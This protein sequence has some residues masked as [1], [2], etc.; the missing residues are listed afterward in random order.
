MKKAVQTVI[1]KAW[2]DEQFRS[3]FIA[4][5]KASIKK[6]T[7]L[8]IPASVKL[9]IND[10]T[11]PNKM[12][13]NIPPKP[14]IDDM[15]LSDEQLEQVAGGEVL[16][17]ALITAGIAMGITAGAA[18]LGGAAAGAAAGINKGW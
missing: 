2:D 4:N 12:F 10:Q 18:V 9:V 6:T 5:P 17:S 3:A 16:V 11:N 8:E 15:E 13:V 1:N 14:N 7:G